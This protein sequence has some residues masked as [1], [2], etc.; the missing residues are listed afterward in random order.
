M[1]YCVTHVR[2]H[3][4][5]LRL[6]PSW[7]NE[8]KIYANGQVVVDRTRASRPETRSTEDAWLENGREFAGTRAPVFRAFDGSW[9]RLIFNWNAATVFQLADLWIRAGHKYRDW[10]GTHA[11]RLLRDLSDPENQPETGSRNR[12]TLPAWHV[13]VENCG[14]LFVFS[15]SFPNSGLKS[16]FSIKVG[17]TDIPLSPGSE[18]ISCIEESLW[19]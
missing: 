10:R 19:T 17:V 4:S 11:S 6:S 18:S 3:A 13:R 5:P 8:P 14:R 15:S 12:A 16:I 1:E 2:T 7:I 9:R